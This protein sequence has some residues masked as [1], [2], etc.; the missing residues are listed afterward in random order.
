MD[1]GQPKPYLWANWDIIRGY[2]WPVTPNGEKNSEIWYEE[3]INLNQGS[4]IEKPGAFGKNLKI[5]D[6]VRIKELC[7]IDDSTT[8]GQNT[9]IE[10]S[11]VWEDVEIGANCDIQESI[12]CNNVK[13]GEN[14][15][16]NESVIGP[17]CI[18][19]DNKKISYQKIV[20]G[21]NDD[22]E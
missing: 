22:S 16:I 11:V 7:V 8:I 19:Q 3:K 2:G 17:N 20:H 21:E 15:R 6:N 10:K 14:V 1:V 13:I 18:V 5:G 4:V 12:I 9:K